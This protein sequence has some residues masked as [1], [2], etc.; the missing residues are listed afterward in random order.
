LLVALIALYAEGQVKMLALALAC[1]EAF[2][3]FPWWFSVLHLFAALNSN[4]DKDFNTFYEGSYA[5]S[6]LRSAFF[7]S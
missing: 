4:Y 2:M 1:M 5:S 7:S 6:L 3:F